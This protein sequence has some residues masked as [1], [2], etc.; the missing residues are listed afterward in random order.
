MHR[1]GTGYGHCVTIARSKN[2]FGPYEGD[3]KNP[4]LTST[5]DF[6]EMDNDDA[7]KLNRYNPNSVL[8]KCGHGSIVE[9]KYDEVYMAYH[10]SRPFLPELR[11][12]LGR[13]TCIQKME[14]TADGWLRMAGGG[15]RAQETTLQS[16]LVGDYP[17]RLSGE[18]FAADRVGLHGFYTPRISAESFASTDTGKGWLRL[19]GQ[20][21]LSSLNRVSLVAQKLTS[22]HMTAQVLMNF[23]PEYYQAYAGLCIY[24]D[25]TNYALLRKAYSEQQDGPV[26]DLLRVRNGE[27]S[28]VENSEVPVEKER[29]LCLQLAVDDHA[30]RFLWGYE[31]EALRSIGPDFDTS[32][33]SDEFCKYGEFTGTFVGLACVDALR[34]V[35]CANFISVNIKRFP[36]PIPPRLPPDLVVAALVQFNTP[37]ISISSIIHHTRSF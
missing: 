31:N 37:S 8:Q 23:E 16:R 30:T 28:Y 36:N 4:I 3:P 25:N 19:R 33:F 13:E 10:C 27:R 21:S 14:W 9:T 32:E 6:D 29:T 11:C 12:T 2:P 24:Y 18:G 1:G 34:H 7:F 15:N 20:E 26:L 35:A 5:G 17:E 22:L